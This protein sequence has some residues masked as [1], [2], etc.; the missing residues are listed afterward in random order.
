MDIVEEFRKVF[1]KKHIIYL[2][3]SHALEKYEGEYKKFNTDLICYFLENSTLD[4]RVF[5]D[6]VAIKSKNMTS[7]ELSHSMLFEGAVLCRE[8]ENGEVFLDMRAFACDVMR[9]C[10][11]IQENFTKDF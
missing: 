1:P 5:G 11:H 4:F 9:V 3:G 2:D 8:I 10:C 6:G 7:T